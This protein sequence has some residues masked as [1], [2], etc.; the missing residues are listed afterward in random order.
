MTREEFNKLPK[1]KQEKILKQA[2]DCFDELFCI[3][4]KSQFNKRSEMTDIEKYANDLMRG[5]FGK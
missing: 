5:V 4:A 3:E 2:C 1:Q